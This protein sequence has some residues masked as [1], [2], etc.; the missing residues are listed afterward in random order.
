MDDANNTIMMEWGAGTITRV[1]DGTNSRNTDTTDLNSIERV[2]L[3]RSNG[4]QMKTTEKT[5]VTRFLKLRKKCLIHML[6][7]AGTYFF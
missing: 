7:E 2:V 4:L 3:W 1:S 6:N 5:S